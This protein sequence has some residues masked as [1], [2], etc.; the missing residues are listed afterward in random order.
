MK[1]LI[2]LIAVGVVI[3]GLIVALILVRNAD[4]EEEPEGFD[5]SLPTE[6]DPDR[7]R[8]LESAQSEIQSVQVEI[9]GQEP[10]VIARTEDDSFRPV[11]EYDVAFIQPSVNRIAAQGA[12]L[13]SRR[14]IGEVESL[15]DFGLDDPQAVI[16]VTRTD[17]TEQVLQVGDLNPGRDAYYVTRPDDPQVYSVFNTWIRTFL[18][19]LDSLR[20]RTI[21]V[22][23]VE[24]LERLEMTTFEGRTIVA[25]TLPEWDDDP[26]MGFAVYAITEAYDRRFQAN[27]NWFETLS[28]T[29]A[30]LQIV[31]F[32]DDAPTNLS[33]YGLAPPAGELTIRDPNG[34]L[35]FEIG[36]E[37][38]GG[39]FAR[40]AGSQTVL[41]LSGAEEIF[42]VE[43]YD[44]I[45]AFALILNI[46]LVDR[47][48]LTTP[49]ATYV[50]RIEREG[51]DDDLVETYFLNDVAVDEDL[52]KDLYQF[53]IG[54][55][56]DAEI[57]G[58]ENGPV[59]IDAAPIAT[60]SYELN[61]GQGTRSVSVAPYTAAFGAVIRDGG[62]EFIVSQGKIDRMIAAFADA[63]E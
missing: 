9:D 19:D 20:E 31:R 24:A 34:E 40:F 51:A 15:A 16:T 49:E 38:E 50:G 2:R 30:G 55:Q 37:T 53:A 11:Y 17:G 57:E 63:V 6:D 7:V 41:V 12:S 10:L 1:R 45:S 3:V 46:D 47:F 23:A 52:F 60:L 21:P 26:E 54:L 18:T 61:N 32:V 14:V 25:Q 44:T 28:G 42:A 29:L 39:R 8:L 43:A 48:S 4:Q 59:R 35:S 33:Q 62:A 27:T 13:S 36:A 22:V 5:F 58:V 56:F